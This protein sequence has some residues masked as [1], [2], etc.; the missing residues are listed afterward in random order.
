MAHV[1]TGYTMPIVDGTEIWVHDYNS[2]EGT[3]P[4]STTRSG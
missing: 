4:T 1:R 3:A 2:Q